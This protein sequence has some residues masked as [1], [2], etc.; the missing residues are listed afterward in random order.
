MRVH[1]LISILL[2]IESRGMIKA[3]DIASKLEVSVRTVYRD[4]DLLCQAGIPIAA[5]TGPNGGVQL[6]EG[7]SGGIRQLQ[8]EDIINLY[9]C[10]MG[11]LPDKQSDMSLKLNNAILKLQKSLSA[12]QS[13]DL[14]NLKRRFYFDA[15]PWW[16]ERKTLHNMDGI[17][18]S[19]FH[20]KVINVAYKKHNG[21]I[22]VRRVHPY[23]I[24]VKRMDWYL[25]AYCEKSKDI[26][27]FKCERIT[28][29]EVL[30]DNFN[31]PIDFHIE[32]YWKRSE[33]VFKASRAEEEIYTV[34]IKV[35]NS[36]ADILS[37]LG[38][39][40][41]KEAEDCILAKVN[42]YSYEYAV[43]NL[44]KNIR[45]VDIYEPLELRDAV[46]KELEKI[47]RKY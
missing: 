46:R 29:C 15:E 47:L 17:M 8:E 13:N 34:V 21:D 42:M 20:S 3:K 28:G 36:C 35:H 33:G 12:K 19:V 39:Y 1:R 23:G 31:T 22:S 44:I 2:L 24:V 25:A 26:R 30:E 18:H 38:V 5:S 6:M 27:T 10:G 9:L 14:N 37:E 4:I 40:E 45:Y 32:E 11:I 7:Y 41:V 16:G 43:D